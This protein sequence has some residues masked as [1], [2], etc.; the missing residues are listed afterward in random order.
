MIAYSPAA[1]P[2]QNFKW[3]PNGVTYD[4]TLRFFRGLMYATIRTEEGAVYVG[5][6][7][8]VNRQWLIPWRRA[9]MGDGNF[10]FEDDY[11]QYPDYRNF[12]TS[13]R[14]VFYSASERILGVA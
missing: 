2:N 1:I 14:L 9:E 12:G 3:T 11:G 6:I 8:C 5:S 13:C 4:F 7:R 10:R